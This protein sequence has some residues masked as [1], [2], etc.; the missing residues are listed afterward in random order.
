MTKDLSPW[1][2]PFPPSR[3]KPTPPAPFSSFTFMEAS[4]F[5]AATKETDVTLYIRENGT[6]NLSSTTAVKGL[7]A[8]LSSL[9]LWTPSSWMSSTAFLQ[10]TTTASF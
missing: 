7:P 1:I 3:V 9:P 6:G 10:I 2:E 5:S 4:C 8:E